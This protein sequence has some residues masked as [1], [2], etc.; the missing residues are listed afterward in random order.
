MPLVRYGVFLVA[1]VVLAVTTAY[2][3]GRPH[4][5]QAFFAL[6]FFVDIYVL[7][8]VLCL[9]PRR[10]GQWVKAV[11]YGCAYA[12]AIAET[13]LYYRFHLY[14]SPTML[15]LLWETNPGE[16]SE[17]VALTLKSRELWNTLL[18]YGS[19]GVGNILAGRWGYRSWK[20]LCGWLHVH[21]HPWMRR[22][23]FAVRFVM[24]PLFALSGLAV[25]LWPWYGEKQKMLAF[26]QNEQ[27]R[28]AEQVPVHTFYT[29]FYRLLH[30]AHFL[31]IAR[32]ETDHLL[33]R[34]QQLQVDSVEGHCPN[35]V[36][37]IGESYNK[38]H[39]QLYGYPL[40]TTP[41]LSQLARCGELLVYTD[42]ISP[43][44]VTSQA[45]KSLLSTHAADEAGT[46]ADGVLFPNVFR[47]AGYK[48]AFAT[49]Q[50]YRSAS[51]D[52]IDFNGSFF[53]N[54]ERM[55]SLNFDFR[56]RF[57]SLTDAQLTDL[58]RSY[59]PAERNLYILHLYGQHMEYHQRYP[60]DKAHFTPTDIERPDLREHER[61]TVA[62]YDNATRFNDEV[63]AR[64]FDYFKQQDALVIYFSDHGEEVYDG[65]SGMY[66]RNHIPEPTPDVLRA[67]Y[68]VPFVV[69]GS[70]RFRQQ[71][72][73]LW[74]RLKA[75]RRQPFS[76]DDLP[77]LL[78][79]LAGIH[80][81]YYQPQRDLLSPQFRPQRRLVKQGVDY[82]KVM[83]HSAP[84]PPTAAE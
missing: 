35:I 52:V 19:I 11:I 81:R 13:Y 53:L 67:E 63:V 1:M 29:P 76:H 72:R 79:G 48:V 34:M 3:V 23:G 66:G 20:A 83:Q 46:W 78:F 73:D 70:R 33:E 50:F 77:H 65:R 25:G 84:T 62:H 58:L 59:T 55:D 57:R 26:L 43:W 28:Q 24:V 42:V 45:F 51:Q 38:H 2:I 16:A 61:Q 6:Q 64:V 14:F 82:D 30:A 39:A 7:C 80:T 10:V 18:I 40:P 17:F 27:T 31:Q 69:W 44:N 4:A 41:H 37:L 47:R 8:A 49:N 68:E 36:V 12:L 60:K 9:L 32:V 71:H 74:Q 5:R 54:E 56:N 21:E 75:A 22:L 15:N